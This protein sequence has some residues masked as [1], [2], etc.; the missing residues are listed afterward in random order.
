MTQFMFVIMSPQS[1]VTLYLQL[2]S[3]TGNAVAAST[4]ASDAAAAA[5]AAMTFASQT[6]DI[7]DK[8][9]KVLGN[10][11]DYLSMTMT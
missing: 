8:E 1:G 2:V 11:L 3:A 9:I 6:L 7:W 10:V 4:S 5:A